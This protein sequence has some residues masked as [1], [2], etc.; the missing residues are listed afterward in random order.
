MGKIVKIPEPLESSFVP[1]R[2]FSRESQINS[3]MESVVF[4][5][6]ERISSTFFVFGQ[7][8]TGKTVT[9]KYI[10]STLSD[11]HV[12]YQNAIGISSFRTIAGRVMQSGVA[13]SVDKSSYELIFKNIS[14]TFEKPILLIVDEC[15]NLVR[16][17]PEGLYQLTRSSELYGIHMGIILVSV[18]NPAL[19]MS[20]GEIRRLGLFNEI[21]FPKYSVEELHGI[22]EDRVSMSLFP[23]TISD[24]LLWNISEISS[25]SGSARMA[26][27]IL[28]KSAFMA[29]YAQSPS[30]LPENIRSAA[31]LINPYI[32]ESKLMEMDRR[33][34]IVLL[35]LCQLLDKISS[36]PV[37]DLEE[38]SK[39]NFENYNLFPP[40]Q[41][42]IYRSV[43]HLETL[44][45]ITSTKKG[46]GKG[47]GV[48]KFLGIN[49]TPVST[50][51][52][53]IYEI[54]D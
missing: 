43:K 52:Q 31:S 49:D 44:D 22:L 39:I 16:T 27:E 11:F 42:F 15:L 46:Q 38:Q 21:R 18:D 34:L 53:K 3:L 28:Q 33:E 45:I 14:R 24:S 4:P 6:R 12:S 51:M 50:L 8:G 29:E 48:K 41:S 40:D 20:S 2:L 25:N 23:G 35:S 5:A 19:H 36:V 47:S 32:T 37:D 1:S 54:L 17:D 9:L 10:K 13:G 26:I 7:S 30:I